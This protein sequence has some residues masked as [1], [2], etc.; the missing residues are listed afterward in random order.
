VFSYIGSDSRTLGQARRKGEPAGVPNAATALMYDDEDAGLDQRLERVA[1][2][3]VAPAG[4]DTRLGHGLGRRREL[5][6]VPVREP[7]LRQQEPA[8]AT[9]RVRGQGLVRRPGQ[10]YPRLLAD[11]V[12]A[13]LLV[14]PRAVRGLVDLRRRQGGPRSSCC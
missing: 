14:A 7:E 11:P 8:V 5:V 1:V 6:A 2:A 12:L 9:V 3:L 13:S 10:G 4:D